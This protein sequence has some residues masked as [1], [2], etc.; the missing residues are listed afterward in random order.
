M[1]NFPVG[2][3]AVVGLYMDTDEIRVS[4]CGWRPRPFRYVVGG[5]I[6]P[7]LVLTASLLL[8][9]ALFGPVYLWQRHRHLGV[10]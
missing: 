4:G 6:P 7:F 10:P 9:A 2:G 3:L 5:A 8:S 1:G